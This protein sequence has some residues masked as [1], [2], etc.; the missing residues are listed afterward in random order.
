M[1]KNDEKWNEKRNNLCKFGWAVLFFLSEATVRVRHPVGH[2]IWSC[3]G[4]WLKKLIQYRSPSSL[5]SCRYHSFCILQQPLS[6]YVPVSVRLSVSLSRLCPPPPPPPLFCAPIPLP[7]A[8]F[9]SRISPSSLVS[10]SSLSP[11][12]SRPSALY[13]FCRPQ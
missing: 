6:V 12:L 1:V 10:V 9:S 4:L 7:R 5:S 8:L 11:N 3:V 2:S 13:V